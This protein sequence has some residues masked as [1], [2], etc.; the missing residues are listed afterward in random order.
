M[1]VVIE[2]IHITCRHAKLKTLLPGIS[3]QPVKQAEAVINNQTK[4]Y[5]KA[6]WYAI[7]ALTMMTILLIVYIFLSNQKCTIFKRRLYSN[8]VTIMLFFSDVKQYI[9]VKL[10]KS[11]GSIHLFQPYGQLDS[12]QIVLEKN[13]L[14][15]MIKMDWKEVFVTLNGTI[16]KMPKS[17]KVPLRDKYRLKTLVEKTFLTIAHYAK[18]R[19]ILVCIR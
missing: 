15:D 19:N 8:T 7:A 17:V 2:I 18:T 9:L 16:I 10:C 3:F 14:W 11:T 6:Q 5:C 4:E 12:D 1:L 13:C